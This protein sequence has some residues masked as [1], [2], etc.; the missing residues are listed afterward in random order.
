MAAS[1]IW[2]LALST[3]VTNG[4]PRP[5]WLLDLHRFLG[6]AAL[7][8]TGIHVGSIM[9]D[10]YVHFGP[11]EVLVPL[12]GNWHPLAVGWG[13]VST[14]LLA[15]VELTSLLRRRISKRLWRSVH[16]ASFAVFVLSTVHLLTA[17]TDR[18]E[19]ALRVGVYVTVATVVALTALRVHQATHPGPGRASTLKP[20]ISLGEAR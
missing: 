18:S 10:S 15:A 13:I 11:T 12:T 14:Y 20:R 1:V 2:G 7:V 19:P 16:F 4:R 3:K 8:F 5:N 6:A 9:L 17:G